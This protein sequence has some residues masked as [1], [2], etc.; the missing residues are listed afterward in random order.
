MSVAAA[1]LKKKLEAYEEVVIDV[2]WAQWPYVGRLGCEAGAASRPTGASSAGGLALEC[3]SSTTSFSFRAEDGIRALTVTGVQTC[4][5][6]ISARRRP[7][8]RGRPA[9]RPDRADPAGDR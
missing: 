2:Q 7:G 3:A 9:R 8:C 5:L 4:A 1:T 6:P